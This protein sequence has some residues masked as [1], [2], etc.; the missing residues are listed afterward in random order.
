MVTAYSEVIPGS[1]LHR[2]DNADE[3]FLWTLFTPCHVTAGGRTVSVPAGSVVIIP[4]GESS[5][6]FAGT[7][8]VWR[9]FTSLNDDLLEKAPNSRE[10]AERPSGVA[11]VQAWPMPPDGYQIRVYNLDDTPAG[12]PHCYVHRTSMT[13]LA[14]PVATSPRR[15]DAMSPHSHDDFEQVSIIHS[16]TMVHHMRRAWSR[17]LHEWLPDEHEI[18]TA[19]AVVISRPPDIHTTQ[20]VT[21]GERVGLIDFFAPVRWDFSNIDGMVVNRAEYPMLPRQP[22]SHAAAAMVY[23]ASDPRAALNRSQK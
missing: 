4:P 18:L 21:A 8:A 9:G 2:A 3:Y 16:G 1:V 17:N 11:P 15:T 12:K 19:P 23:A 10:Y 6:L 22:K 20:A 7:G 5:V 13:N 14:W